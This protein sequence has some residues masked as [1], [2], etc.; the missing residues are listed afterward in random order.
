VVIS[1]GSITILLHEP[2]LM[3]ATGSKMQPSGNLEGVKGC[4]AAVGQEVDLMTDRLK[5]AIRSYS[6][7]LV[8][9]Q[10]TMKQTF[11]KK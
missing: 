5:M 9:L 2:G 10:V 11:P 6:L 4:K 3:F 8:V 1:S 7:D